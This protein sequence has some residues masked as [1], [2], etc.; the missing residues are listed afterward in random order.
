ML[1]QGAALGLLVFYAGGCPEVKIEFSSR[2]G[3]PQFLLVVKKLDNP[4]SI[5]GL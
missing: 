1:F 4:P 5:G 3:I 2:R